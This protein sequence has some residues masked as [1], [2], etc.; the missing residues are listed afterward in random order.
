MRT[1]IRSFLLISFV[2]ISPNIF[3]ATATISDSIDIRHFTI[4]MDITDYAGETIKGNAELHIAAKVDNIIQIPLDLLALDVDSV[5]DE[6]GN[7]LSFTHIGEKLTINF[8]STLNTNDSIII[9]IFYGGE[10]AADGSW[11]GWYWSGDYSFQLGVG[12]D[13]IPHNY[14]RIWFP[15]FD[16]FIERSTFRYEIITEDDKKAVCGGL[17]ESEIDNGDGTITWIWNCNQTIP[18]YLASVA[19]STYAFV[20]KTYNGIAADIPIMIAARSEDTADVNG[21]FINLNSAL[22][23]FET[24]YG[25]YQWDRVGYSVVPFGGGAMEHAM[26]IA[27]PLFAVNGTTVWELLFV[28]ELSHMWWGDLITTSKAEEMWMNEGWAVYS[29]HLFTENLYGVDAYKDI[30]KANHLAVLHYAASDD[31]NNYFPISDVAEEFTYGSTTYKKGADV[32][33]SLRGYMGDEMFFDCITSFLE[34]YKFQP[35]TA[36]MLRDHL[37]TCSG[38]IIDM[39]DFFDGWVYQPGFPAFEIDDIGYND[40]GA[41]INICIEQKLHHANNYCNNVPLNISFFDE[42]WNLVTDILVFMS[43][44]NMQIELPA[45]EAKYA[46]IDYNENIN[47]AITEDE[48]VI[49]AADTYNLP[50]GLIDIT[51]NSITDSAVIYAQHYWVAADNFKTPHPGL[52]VNSQRYWK[53]SGIISVDFDASAKFLFNGQNLSGGYLDNEFITNSDD[54]LV[55][56]F[57]NSPS[58]E[59]EIYSFYELNTWGSTS[60]KKGAFELSKLQM[61]EYAFGIY[62][63]EIP[64]APVDVNM[65]CPDFLGIELEEGNYLKIFPNPANDILSIQLKNVTEGLQLKLI[66][67]SGDTVKIIPVKY[68]S[69][70]ISVK[71]LASGTYQLYVENAQFERIAAQKLMIIH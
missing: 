44:E 4:R 64:D 48:I 2:V 5:K 14:G 26:N 66:N 62:D 34:T 56:L 7:L 45:V 15:C 40:Y 11:G 68:S 37:T 36:A 10:P 33:H 54:S 70:S 1:I 43:G 42:E 23:I 60:D 24:H 20:N 55:L 35:V 59:W 9:T 6:S 25:P 3:A 52:H 63:A 57:R 16:N 32:I 8:A 65:D 30:V 51:V 19:V 58:A 22:N 31:G 67:A 18:S 27:Y 29:E 17:L 28:H 47:D 12:F 49:K 46:I 39:N 50:N 53:I 41:M 38:F 61:G 13:A 69:Q 71:D 21:S